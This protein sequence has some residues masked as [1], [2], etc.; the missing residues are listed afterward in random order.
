MRYYF[1]RHGES[2]ANAA[3]RYQTKS[4][5]LSAAGRRQAQL[6][7]R[8]FDDITIDIILTSDYVRT[9]ETAEIINQPLGVPIHETTLLQELH[10][11]PELEGKV[12]DDPE[13][14]PVI[15]ALER[16]WDD[17]LWHYST[18]ENLNDLL[19]RAQLFCALLLDRDEE[20]ILVVT[21]GAT[22]KMI[23]TVMIFGDEASAPVFRKFNRSFDM[24]NT[25]ITWC[26]HTD[27]GRWLVHGW[28]DVE[29]LG[30]EARPNMA[31][32]ERN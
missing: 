22:L 9:L 11:P 23:L 6:L 7:A 21:H 25:G 17:P 29:H 4:T 27:D 2:V 5:P 20:R 13:A 31:R 12:Y 32:F 10:S 8:R 15:K 1:V 14:R 16:H 26:E 18:E 3:G 19:A 28:N 24:S 30:E